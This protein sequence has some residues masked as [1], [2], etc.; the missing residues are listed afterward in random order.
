MIGERFLDAFC[1]E[2]HGRLNCI[3]APTQS[4]R[5]TVQND[6]VQTSGLR[7]LALA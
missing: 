5:V 6:A 1:G 4:L 3:A 2:E 7:A